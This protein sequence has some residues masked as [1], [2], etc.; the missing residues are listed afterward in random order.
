MP[1]SILKRKKQPYRAPDALSFAG[2]DWVEDLMSDVPRA[3]LFDDKA[4][5]ALWHKVKAKRDESQLSNADNMALV[6]V[7]STQLLHRQFVVQT[8]AR[9]D[10]VEWTTRKEL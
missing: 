2:V 5:A 9:V 3:G 6:G 1:E 8:P 10:S 7:I 4:I